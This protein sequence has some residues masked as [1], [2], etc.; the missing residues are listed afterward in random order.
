ML[1]GQ[2]EGAALQQLWEASEGNLQYLR[3]LVL[4]G[5]DAGTLVDDAGLWRTVGAI[6][7][8]ARLQDLVGERL[9]GLDDDEVATLELV[10]FGEPLG[11]D[12]LAGLVGVRCPGA[13]RAQ[14]TGGDGNGRAPLRGQPGPSRPR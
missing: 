6:S 13:A 4:A 1:G 14:G 7:P 8:S 12:V 2:V 11:V 3:E 9:A 10:A 5:V